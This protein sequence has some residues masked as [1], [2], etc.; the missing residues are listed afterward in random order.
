MT[1]LL[2]MAKAPVPGT[3]K[4]RLCPP[5]TP[6]QAA[7]IASAA[8]LDTAEAVQGTTALTPVLACAGRLRAGVA[9]E[10]LVAAFA[11]WRVLPQRG[12]GLGDR[13][14]NAHADV[15]TAFPGR[16]VLQIGMD[17]P[18]LSPDL[19]D[20]AA[21]R[22]DD[23]SAVL[24]AA[25]D[26]GW[27]ALGLRDPRH[28]TVLRAVPMSTPDTG[29]RTHAALESRGLTVASLPVLRDADEW[30]DALAVAAAAPGGRFAREVA[31]VRA[32]LV[33]G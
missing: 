16:A 12:A 3:V 19:L 2:V 28:A 20:A 17:T 7:R 9:G 27:W 18:Q 23:A 10:A 5:A 13:L 31:A 26:G 15:A 21:R 22:L 11:G 8:L 1:V 32:T 25:A 6:E 24:G 29:R 33:S 14:A 4:T 30:P